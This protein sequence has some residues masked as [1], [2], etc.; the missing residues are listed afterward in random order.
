MLQEYDTNLESSIRSPDGFLYN[1]D[2]TSVY[3]LCAKIDHG[4]FLTEQSL[5]IGN[6]NF[7]DEFVDNYLEN[8]YSWKNMTIHDQQTALENVCP[9]LCSEPTMR[10]RL[11]YMLGAYKN[12]EMP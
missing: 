6:A 3:D 5:H 7:K 1:Q 9:S 4:D 11:M 8:K 10:R 12:L 2:I